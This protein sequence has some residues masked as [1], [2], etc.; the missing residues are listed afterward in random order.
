MLIQLAAVS[1]YEQPITQLYK[2]L[3]FRN[4]FL[5]QNYR[6]RADTVYADL[7]LRL[8]YGQLNG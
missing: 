8:R 7:L 6:K 2:S 3:L 1:T 4:N 5:T